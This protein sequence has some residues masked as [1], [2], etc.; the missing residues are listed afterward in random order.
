MIAVAGDILQHAHMKI[1]FV[2]C[3]E[4]VAVVQKVRDNEKCLM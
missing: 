1:M 2:L 4:I 3:K